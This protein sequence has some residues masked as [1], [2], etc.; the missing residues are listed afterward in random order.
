MYILLVY[1]CV[2]E[3]LLVL[4]LLTMLPYNNFGL[5]SHESQFKVVCKVKAVSFPYLA[6]YLLVSQL[7][8]MFHRQYS[9]LI[10]VSIK[11]K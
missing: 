5:I 3:Y 1:F 2:L 11:F 9:C 8:A 7:F 6:R 4:K 10:S